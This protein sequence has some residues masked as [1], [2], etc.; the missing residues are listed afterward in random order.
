[1]VLLIG[2]LLSL[3]VAPRAEVD[4]AVVLFHKGVEAYQQ[5]E[6]QNAVSDFE[7]ALSLGYE[8]VEL[9]YNLGN[10]YFKVNDI[11]KCILNYE[12][13]KKLSPGDKDISYNLQLAQLYVVDKIVV[14]PQHFIGRTIEVM[15][16][17]L[18]KNQLALI[19]VF[20]HII[21]V[22]AL[23]LRML[24]RRAG[25]KRYAKGIFAT[26]LVLFLFT[27]VIF[28]YRLRDDL[29]NRQGI[30]L[31]EKIEV[32]SSPAGDATEVFALHQGA[33]VNLHGQS[34]DYYQISLPDGKVGW[35]LRSSLEII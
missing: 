12:R 18:S 25:V 8:S 11:G 3:A 24:I 1:M 28:A 22:S 17:T 19:L 29:R 26:F 7:S 23:I 20:F 10:A 14:P 31:A 6:Y 34:G 30:I 4:Q 32:Q 33:K 2:T 5:T 16:H 35:L 9:Y 15:A 27:S 21:W 13:A